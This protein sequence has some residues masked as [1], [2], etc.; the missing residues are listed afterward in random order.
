M[1]GQKAFTNLIVCVS[2]DTVCPQ[3]HS[4]HKKGITEGS[5]GMIEKSSGG[6]VYVALKLRD[7]L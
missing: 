4:I 5:K 2:I 1:E 6:K 7:V 3:K